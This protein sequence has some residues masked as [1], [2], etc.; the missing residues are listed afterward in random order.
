MSPVLRMLFYT[1]RIRRLSACHVRNWRS[2][3][4]PFPSRRELWS[5]SI[6]RF[7]CHRYR[8]SPIRPHRPSLVLTGI[9]HQW[10]ARLLTGYL[11]KIKKNKKLVIFTVLNSVVL[12]LLVFATVCIGFIANSTNKGDVYQSSSNIEFDL[13]LVFV[14]LSI[15]FAIIEMLLIIFTIRAKK[16]L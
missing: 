12:F 13:F 14:I 2:R 1:I 10:S 15:C 16:R 6:P 5:Y 7:S 3:I 9:L 4:L 8:R 11:I